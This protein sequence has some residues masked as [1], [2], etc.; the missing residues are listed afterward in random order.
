MRRWHRPGGEDLL[1]ARER[2]RLVRIQ[3]RIGQGKL[4]DVVE[5]KSDATERRRRDR[6]KQHRVDGAKHGSVCADAEGKGDQ[7]DN[8]EDAALIELAHRETKIARESISPFVATHNVL[9]LVRKCA[10]GA[11]DS[12]TVSE[13]FSGEASSGFGRHALLDVVRNQ[14]V[15]M[16]LDFVANVGGDVRAPEAEVAS[17][18]LAQSG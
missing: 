9:P 15:E 2:Q 14:R 13:A 5:D 3:R 17:P 7:R 10:H 18:T 1:A 12:V 6:M 16:E 11:R 4:R 8:G